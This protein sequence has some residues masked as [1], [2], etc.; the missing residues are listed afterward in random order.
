MRLESYLKTR[1]LGQSEFA[2]KAGISQS[3]VWDAL[4]GRGLS[5]WNALKVEAATEGEVTV[6]DLLP[7]GRRGA[8]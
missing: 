6:A 8:A 2:R 4:Q 3:R 5:T 1:G 7:E